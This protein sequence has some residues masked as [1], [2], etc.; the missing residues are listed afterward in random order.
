MRDYEFT[1]VVQPELEDEDR[2]TLVEQVQGWVTEQGG[3]VL[4]VDNWGQR[5]LAY[6]IRD[7]KQGY[8]FLMH[9]Q[10]PPGDGVRELERRMQIAEPI[11]RYLTVRVEQ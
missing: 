1:F 4:K 10:F 11:L 8:Y 3:A 6:P 2:A 9:I 7:H 5:R